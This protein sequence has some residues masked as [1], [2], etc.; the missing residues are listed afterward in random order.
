MKVIASSPLF[1][2]HY[3]EYVHPIFAG[4]DMDKAFP[5]LE[6]HLVR[7]QDMPTGGANS[8]RPH[9]N[10]NTNRIFIP[11]V[12]LIDVPKSVKWRAKRQ[13]IG[14]E[15]GHAVH[16]IHMPANSRTCPRWQQF[17]VLSGSSLDFSWRTTDFGGRPYPHVLA[18]E[19]F[20]DEFGYW[21]N[22]RRPGPD[23]KRF[24]LNLW[25]Q[26]YKMKIELYVGKK[27]AL[28]DGREVSLDVPPTVID[29]RTMVP[30]R[31][32]AEQMGL[33]VDW[34]QAEKKVT[35]TG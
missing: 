4:I 8:H 6:L 34:D 3:Y 27:F 13:L 30:I 7:P 2:M 18:F 23:Y 10:P 11:V 25:G 16:T 24:Y 15:T 33:K 5:G 32:V 22:E 9:Y 20:A 17:G 21:L 31:F 26:E 14:H 28:V 29:N 19:E 1:L 12:E 35:I